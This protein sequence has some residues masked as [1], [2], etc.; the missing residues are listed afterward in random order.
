MKVT[1]EINTKEQAEFLTSALAS[2]Y[3]AFAGSRCIS[4]EK[5]A[6]LRGIYKA[7]NDQLEELDSLAFGD[8][9]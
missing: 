2:Y 7:L 6:E 3:A 9:A 4:K 1:L 5:K 8:A